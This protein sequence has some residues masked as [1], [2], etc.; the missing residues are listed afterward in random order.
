TPGFGADGVDPPDAR[1]SRIPC[2]D[3]PA[4]RSRSAAAGTRGPPDCDTYASPEDA[5]LSAR[6]GFRSEAQAGPRRTVC[7]D[8]CGSPTANPRRSVELWT[9]TMGYALERSPWR[10]ESAVLL[11]KVRAAP[12]DR[13]EVMTSRYVRPT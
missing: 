8:S 2:P 4:P 7:P 6:D 13:R 12:P 3:F 1:G 9:N 5:S 10:G 11:C